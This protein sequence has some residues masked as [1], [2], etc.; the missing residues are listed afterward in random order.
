MQDIRAFSTSA[1]IGLARNMPMARGWDE[2][3]EGAFIPVDEDDDDRIA[4]VYK[5]GD[6]PPEITIFETADNVQ[7][8]CANGVAVAVVA[9]CESPKLTVNDI[10]LVERYDRRS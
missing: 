4:V 10:L 3:P 8:V 7:T 1:D 6:A 9:G 2:M 5:S